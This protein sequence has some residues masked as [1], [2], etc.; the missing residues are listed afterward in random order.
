MILE[1]KN[2]NSY[3]VLP[4]CTKVG[5]HYFPVPKFIQKLHIFPD[6]SSIERQ[7]DLFILL[8]T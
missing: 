3:A 1:E 2:Y 8:L 7:D 4:Q 5:C 6:F